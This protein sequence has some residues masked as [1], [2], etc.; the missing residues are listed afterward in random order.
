M[1]T[2]ENLPNGASY[3]VKSAIDVNLIGPRDAFDAIDRDLLSATVDFDDVRV[4]PDGSFTAKAVI[5]L[6]ADYEFIYV[7]NLD[8]E[9]TF[10]IN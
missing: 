3:N 4:N 10:T 7:Q 2:V 1:I 8:Y 9:V 5:S 6:G